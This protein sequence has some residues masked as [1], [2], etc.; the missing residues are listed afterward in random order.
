MF[1]FELS[2]VG[3]LP[4]QYL[5]RGPGAVYIGLVTTVEGIISSRDDRILSYE[6]T[7]SAEEHISR[8]CSSPCTLHHQPL[9][10][11]TT[12]HTGVGYYTTMV[13]RT[14]INLVSLV[15]FIVLA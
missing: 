14:S 4:A 11:S 10:Q 6:N 3:A 13:A 9:R 8:G 5:G 1:H 2:V 7:T 12:P 15:L